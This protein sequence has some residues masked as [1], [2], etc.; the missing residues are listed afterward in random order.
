MSQIVAQ[1]ALY[2][3]FIFSYTVTVDVSVLDIDDNPPSFNGVTRLNASITE[4]SPQ[5]TP[6]QLSTDITVKD[7]DKVW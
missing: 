7:I 5:N 2:H 6:L 4:E 1:P 3:L